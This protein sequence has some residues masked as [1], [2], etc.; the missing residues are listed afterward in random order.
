MVA[1]LWFA[2]HRYKYVHRGAQFTMPW[3]KPVRY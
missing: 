1:S 3:P 2:L